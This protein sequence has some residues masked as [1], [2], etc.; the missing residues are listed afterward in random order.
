MSMLLMLDTNAASALVKGRAAQL[1]A[2]L[3]LR[4]P[5]IFPYDP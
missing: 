2:R 5:L 4:D 3:S 1:S